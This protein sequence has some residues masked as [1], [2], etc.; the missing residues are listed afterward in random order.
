MFRYRQ[1][2]S[3]KSGSVTE[4]LQSVFILHSFEFLS[5]NFN[6]IPQA[7]SIFPFFKVL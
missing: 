2:L 4:V 3:V 6:V 1:N 5:V 7:S